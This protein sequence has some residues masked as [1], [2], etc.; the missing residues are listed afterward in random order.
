MTISYSRLALQMHM[1]P[2]DPKPSLAHLVVSSDITSMIIR[3]LIFLMISCAILSPRVMIKLLSEWLNR[4][5]LRD[6]L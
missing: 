3:L 2:V 1:L 5:M 4:I 6:P